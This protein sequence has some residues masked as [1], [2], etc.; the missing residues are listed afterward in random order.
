MRGKVWCTKIWEPATLIFFLGL[1]GVIQA[2][3]GNQVNLE[4]EK[5][6]SNYP[7]EPRQPTQGRT[8]WSN[9]ET[10]SKKLV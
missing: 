8:G 5:L 9:D 3:L 7:I 1:G 6:A 2:S 4:A 10:I